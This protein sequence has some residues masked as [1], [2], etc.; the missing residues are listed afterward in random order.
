M[1]GSSLKTDYMQ[2]VKSRTVL[3]TVVKNL[4]L[5]KELS[6]GGL[7]AATSVSNPTDTRILN[8]T[9]TY[10]DPRMAK[11]L[12][13]ELTN[14]AIKRI[15]EIMDTKE[16]KVFE[17]GNISTSPVSPNMK[18]NV[19]IAAL[20]GV[21]LSSVIVIVIY[22]MDD[23]IRSVED[24]EKYLD[25][26][27]LASIPISEGSET[28]VRLDNIKRRGTNKFISKFIVLFRMGRKQ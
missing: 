5:E 23:T 13:D 9:V 6:G 24:I 14:V 26:N 7:G 21:L 11:E 27:T 20:F 3:D 17:W 4:G 16:P 1:L 10:K 15:S 28:E 12:V 22:L 25:L 8:V 2:L 18:K 19:A